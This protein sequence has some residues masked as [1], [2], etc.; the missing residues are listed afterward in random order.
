[1]KLELG[2]SFDCPDVGEDV[3]WY[4]AIET[5]PIGGGCR[6]D[7]IGRPVDRRRRALPDHPIVPKPE[8]IQ[9]SPA[10]KG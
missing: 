3:V 4:A 7:T 6:I 2:D 9:R 1:M 10:T 5:K 8:D